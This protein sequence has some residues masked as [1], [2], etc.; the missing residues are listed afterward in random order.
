MNLHII[1][2]VLLVIAAPSFHKVCIM[3]QNNS[4][5]STLKGLMTFLE[6]IKIVG[7]YRHNSVTIK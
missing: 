6:Q 1:I 7:Q 2:L 5:M 4:H 3:N